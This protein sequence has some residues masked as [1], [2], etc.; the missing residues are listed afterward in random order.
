MSHRACRRLGR[1]AGNMALMKPRSDTPRHL[2]VEGC[3]QDAVQLHG[4]LALRD[5]PRL[6]DM[7]HADALP[8]AHDGS[9]HW[10]A[11]GEARAQQ[12]GAPQ[13]WLHVQAHAP[14]Q[15]VCQRCLNAVAVTVEVDRHI[16]FVRGEDAAAE[17]DAEIEDD[18]IAVPRLLDLHEL[19]EDELLLA[20]PLVP[21]H[22][23]CPEPLAAPAEAAPLEEAPHPF[24]ALAGLKRRG[25]AN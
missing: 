14:M 12:G 25:S 6:M 18:V 4:T 21:R 3:A 7:A 9:V 5:L 11:Q 16:R 1:P 22:D 8:V 2:D 13:I 19:V 20:L 24:A 10:Q 15:L 17:L 23:V